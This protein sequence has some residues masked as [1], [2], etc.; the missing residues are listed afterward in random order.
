MRPTGSG[1][2]GGR[3]E[4][5]GATDQRSVSQVQATLAGSDLGG[6]ADVDPPVRF[7]FSSAPLKPGSVELRTS[8]RLGDG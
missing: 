4:W 6:L 2:G 8:I 7:G 1:S 3:T 5:Y